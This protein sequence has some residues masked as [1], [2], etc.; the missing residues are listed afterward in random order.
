MCATSH[1]GKLTSLLTTIFNGVTEGGGVIAGHRSHN[2]P[3]AT[4]QIS[5]WTVGSRTWTVGM[6]ANK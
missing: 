2:F 6:F 5:S 3:S 4:E 1:G